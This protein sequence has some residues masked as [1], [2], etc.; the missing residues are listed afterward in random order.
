MKE[1]HF[2]PLNMQAKLES[3][4][5]STKVESQDEPQIIVHCMDPLFSV[6]E[7]SS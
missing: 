6:Q 2:S 5:E 1:S 7:G 4:D 3:I